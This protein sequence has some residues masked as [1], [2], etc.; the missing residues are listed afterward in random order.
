MTEHASIFDLMLVA[1]LLVL[2]V[3]IR[4]LE[5]KLRDRADENE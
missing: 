4:S 5:R 2:A 3:R 1:Y